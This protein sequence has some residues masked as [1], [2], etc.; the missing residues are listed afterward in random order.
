LSHRFY[1]AESDRAAPYYEELQQRFRAEW[2]EVQPM[3]TTGHAVPEPVVALTTSD[4]LAGG[5]SFIAA[6]SPLNEQPAIW[7]NAVLVEPGY[8]RGGLGSR[9]IAFSAL[10]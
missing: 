2:P 9:L 6:K 8:R 10:E 1:I 5:L 4:T 7:I 3:E